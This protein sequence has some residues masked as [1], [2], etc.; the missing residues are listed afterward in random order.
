MKVKLF[1]VTYR[2]SQDLITNLESIFAS[3]WAGHHLEISIINN[4]S[5][6]FLP[7]RLLHRVAVLHNVCRPD[8]STG[9]LSRNWNQAIINGFKNL[10]NPDCDIL[11]HCQDDT[12]FEPNWFYQLLDYHTKYSFIQM[13]AGDNFCSYTP[14][15]VKNIGLWDERFC[16]IGFQE[17]DYFLRARIYNKQ[18][19]SINDSYHRRILNEVPTKICRRTKASGFSTYHVKSSKYHMINKNLF[20]KKWGV[21]PE[22]WDLSMELPSKSLIE[23]Y[24][25]YPYFELDINSLEEKNFV[26][27]GNN[28]DFNL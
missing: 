1:I 5:D 27:N 11:I 19:S 13:G 24:I 3:N 7:P 23:N 4:H 25:F 16:G 22:N 17:A 6:F 2:N 8:F 20:E 18:F 26:V 15:A 9:H 14:A 28:V 12:V 21:P 10:N